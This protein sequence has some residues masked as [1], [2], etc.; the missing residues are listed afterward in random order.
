VFKP[1]LFFKPNGKPRQYGV[2]YDE[3]SYK[4]TM[5]TVHVAIIVFVLFALKFQ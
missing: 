1:S 5:F 2:G 3:E 4:K